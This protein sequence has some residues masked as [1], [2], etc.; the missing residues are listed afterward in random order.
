MAVYNILSRWHSLTIHFISYDNHDFMVS[1]LNSFTKFFDYHQKRISVR[2]YKSSVNLAKILK[3][4]INLPNTFNL[5]TEKAK[6]ENIV[7]KNRLESIF[8]QRRIYKKN[9]NIDL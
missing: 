8:E 6:Y 4:A 5:K 1:Q 2:S 3:T 7:F 9:N